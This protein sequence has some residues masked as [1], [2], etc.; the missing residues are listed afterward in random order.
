MIWHA[1]SNGSVGIVALVI[2]LAER[3]NIRSYIGYTN[4]IERAVPSESRREKGGIPLVKLTEL[5]LAAAI[6]IAFVVVLIL[7]V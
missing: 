5:L 4:G 6:L 3:K 2:R 1:I 7:V